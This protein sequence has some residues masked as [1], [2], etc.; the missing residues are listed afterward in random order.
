MATHELKTWPEPF[1]AIWRGS[2]LYE[3]RKADR[4]FR[5]GDTVIL[6]E[7]V[8]EGHFYTGR[9]VEA[10]ITYLTP[11]GQW[12]LPHDLCVFGIGD[13]KRFTPKSPQRDDDNQQDQ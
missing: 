4:D 5:P 12:E 6:R 10:R 3:I 8:L 2:K 13:I 1:A 9:E 11:G 7:W